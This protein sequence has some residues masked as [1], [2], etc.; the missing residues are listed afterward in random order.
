MRATAVLFFS[1]LQDAKDKAANDRILFTLLCA[2]VCLNTRAAPVLQVGCACRRRISFRLLTV[3]L[4]CADSRDMSVNNRTEFA[5]MFFLWNRPEH[6]MQCLA[7][8]TR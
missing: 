8:H 7:N 2:I 6:V 1:I 4:C 5:R 3:E